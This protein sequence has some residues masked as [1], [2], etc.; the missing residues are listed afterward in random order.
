MFLFIFNALYLVYGE[1]GPKNALYEHQIKKKQTKNKNIEYIILLGDNIISRDKRVTVHADTLG[2]LGPPSVIVQNPPGD[3]WLKDRWQAASDMGGTAIPGIHYVILDFHRYVKA[4]YAVLDW[5]AAYASAY[6]IKV[7]S[8]EDDEWKILFDG[9]NPKNKLLRA[10]NQSGQSPGVKFKL[11][12]HI[13]HSIDLSRSKSVGFRFLQIYIVKPAAG[14]GV[15]LWQV[16][17]YGENFDEDA[18]ANEHNILD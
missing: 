7:K 10:V 14:W 3:N 15:S 2:N 8:L 6:Q 18:T 13:V 11:P 12:L 17:I 5:E 16:D 4:F 1:W 9:R